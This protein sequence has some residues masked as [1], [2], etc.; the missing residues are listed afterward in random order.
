MVEKFISANSMINYLKK[1]GLKNTVILNNYIKAYKFINDRRYKSILVTISGGSDSDIVL[2]ICYRCDIKNKCQYVY[3]DTGIEYKATKDHIKYLEEKYGIRIK[4]VKS[5]KPIPTCC[6]E[7]GQPF[8]SKHVSEMISRLQRHGFMWEND[9]FENLYKKYPKCKVALQWWCNANPE[10]DG[11]KSRFNIEYNKLL[12]EFILENN[13]WFEISNLCCVYAKKLN[14]KMMLQMEHY[15]LNIFGVRKS[16]GGVRAAAY[17]SCFEEGWDNDTYLPIF[18]YS[19]YDKRYY[20]LLFNIKHS[21]CYTKYK[22]K[23]TGCA[24]CPYCLNLEEELKAIKGNEPKLYKAVS[25]IF[26]DSY[27]YTNMY[28]D[29]VS[30]RKGA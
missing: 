26:K 27:K 28:R 16:E 15:D 24:G 9:S 25:S 5:R 23:R 13:P 1:I 6:K 22:L 19:D 30:A 4:V 14:V 18:W 8:I 17:K 10:I 21:D 7:Y 20:E 3:F 12:K 11:H 2:D 29:Y